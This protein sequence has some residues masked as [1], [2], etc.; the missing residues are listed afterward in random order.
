MKYLFFLSGEYPK[1]AQAEVESLFGKVHVLT[2]SLLFL[3]ANDL[4]LALATRLGYTKQIAKILSQGESMDDFTDMILEN[5]YKISLQHIAGEEI[6]LKDLANKLY[7][8]QI[9]PKV[10]IHHPAHHYI[11]Y[12]LEKTIF[13]TEEIYFNDDDPHKRRSHLKLYNHPTS[14]HPKLAKAMINLA[15]TKSFIDPFCGTGGLVIEG[16]LMGLDAK[17]SDISAELVNKAKENAKEFDVVGEFIKKDALHMVKKTPAIITDLPYGKN[18]CVSQEIT[19]LYED[20]FLL[21]QKLTP[22][23]V[24]GI[25]DTTN[26]RSLL[27]SS[28]WNVTKEFSIYMHKSLT[29]KIIVL[30]Q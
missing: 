16:L 25:A 7:A 26:I 5:T 10:N 29:R 8:N 17:G 28:S 2:S 9:N 18:S 12:R 19:S 20:F 3:E 21:A 30:Q 15:G 24:I 4:N 23:L 14:M 1:L 22:C 6:F 13:A 27:K 11:F